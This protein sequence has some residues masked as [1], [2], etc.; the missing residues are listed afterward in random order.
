MQILDQP[1]KAYFGVSLSTKIVKKKLAFWWHMKGI[2]C[3][4]NFFFQI[5][6][7]FLSLVNEKT[8]LIPNFSQPDNSFCKVK[9]LN[10][11]FLNLTKF[12]N[13]SLINALLT[14]HRH[15]QTVF[16]A[17]ES[18]NVKVVVIIQ[19]TK[20]ENSYT[21]NIRNNFKAGSKKNLN[22]KI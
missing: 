8:I 11:F 20:K 17:T 5:Q 2:F 16:I 19:I 10:N 14:L 13:L 3:N 21:K 18:L 6:A 22:G 12:L 4:C 15:S 7:I 1:Q 9:K